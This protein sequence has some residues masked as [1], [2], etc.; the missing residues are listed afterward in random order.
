MRDQNSNEPEI[1]QRDQDAVAEAMLYAQIYNEQ[2]RLLIS[3]PECRARARVAM[4]DFRESRSIHAMKD[5]KPETR[6]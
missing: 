4:E 3:A 6:Q 2:S 5:H 1:P